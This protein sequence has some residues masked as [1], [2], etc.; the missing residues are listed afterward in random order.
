MA[1]KELQTRIALKYDL[2]SAWTSAPGKDL[3]LLKGELGICEIPAVNGDSRVAPT[4]LFKVG[5][6]AKTF[7]KLP[8]AS[9]KAA[10][11]YSWAKA[12]EVK[13]NGKKLVFV[14]GGADGAN[15]EVA[16]DYV[17]LEEVKAITDGLASRVTALEGK[18]GDS[19]DVTKEL[20]NLDGRLDVIEGTGEGSVAKALADAKAY[21]NTRETAITT[22]YE[23]YADQ[24]EA[25]AKSYANTEIAKDRSRITATEGRLDVIEGEGAGSIK[26]AVADAVTD[27]KAYADTA[28][29]DAVATAKGY[30]DTREAAIETAYKAYADQAEA[31]AK[32]YV[33]GKVTTINAKDTEQDAAISANATAIANETAAREQAD[34]AINNKLA[35]IDTT[36]VDAIATAKQAAIDAAATTAQSK[37]DALANGQVNTNKTNIATNAAAITAMDAAY[38]KAV[39]DE[40]T[41]RAEAD[42]A[43]SNRL[44]SI[45]AFFEAADHDGEDGGLTDALDTLKEIQ[46]Y[47]TG[48]GSAAGSLLDRIAEAEGDIDD[49]EAEFATGRVK[50]AEEAI[51]SLKG[52][53]TALEAADTRI[54]GRIDAL[55]GD[56]GT[57]ATGDAATLAS[58]KT[59]TDA[60]E[61]EIKKYADQ[62]ETDAVATAK[63]YTNTELTKAVNTLNAKDTELNT[64]IG[65][66]ATNIT[67]LQN[68]V[69]GYTTKGS[70]KS[71]IEAA[72]T[73]GQQGIDDAATAQAAAEK[74]QGEIDAL[75]LVVGNAN[76]GLAAAHT[77]AG[78]NASDIA[79]LTSRVDT[80]ES[81]I[82]AL[83]ATVNDASKGNTKLRT[84][85]NA[86]QTLTG[87][88]A[89]GNTALYTELTRVAGLV[90]N[91][92]TGLAATKV[93]ADRAD[94]KSIDNAKR[95]K[96]IEDD[97]LKAAD[98]YV[99]NCG[100]AT[101]VTHVVSAN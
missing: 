35:G 47:L 46:T 89:K 67:T 30:T 10:D 52:R 17:T 63:S 15:L 22:A 56:S 45:E 48:E 2:Y 92:T 80:A 69:D 95:I 78:K 6:G 87:D 85:V 14:G 60:R 72:A 98:A 99:F 43:L 86:L 13:R 18:F 62:A 81:D 53:A 75:E 57:I 70:V 88:A 82:D 79:A 40:A 25:D 3:V 16:F 97:Y 41:A 55:V 64:A 34:Q 7:E 84:D 66:N 77:K 36:V 8:W 61:V 59:Y 58:A 26:K 12:S 21:T 83:E 1:I 20:A 32:T 51:E 4:V 37:V 73:K 50:V 93:V 44:D 100:T 38:K 11:V 23:S 42:T 74:A 9:A 76:T 49:L 27:V 65:N 54:D 71:A 94:A 96:A 5:D 31:D 90:D 24:A 68:I 39:G 33:D 101:T 91:G 28:E 19:G 29:S